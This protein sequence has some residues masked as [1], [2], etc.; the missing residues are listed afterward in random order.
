MDLL[1][2]PLQRLL[3]VEPGANLLESL[4]NAQIP[5][6]YSC[7][8]GRC[9]TCRCRVVNGEVLESGQVPQNPFDGRDSYVLACQTYITEPCTIEIPE[10]DEVVVHPARILKTTVQ[11]IEALTHDIRRLVLKPARPIA[12]SPGQYAQLQFTP[13]LVRPYSM[14]GVAGDGMLEFHVRIV[15]GGR[16]S[17]YIAN[18]LRPGDAVRV[19]GPLGTAYLRQKHVGPMLCVA[20]GTG[21]APILSI[22]RSA[23]FGGMRNPVHL[24]FGVR[25]AEDVYGLDWLAD[26]AGRH[27]G[28]KLNVVVTSGS[29]IRGQ[30]RGLVTEAIEEDFDSLEGWRA[31]LC[32]SP[33]MVEAA[34]VLARQMG[35]DPTRIY[36]DAFY[37]Q[38]N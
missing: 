8:A 18:E 20:G 31:Y 2:Q 13:D 21:L 7:M 14:A 10:P 29:E 27:P 16:V 34:T 11:S 4:R 3:D 23:I 32:G 33:P 19:S 38:P 5:M 25:S 36:A 6:S 17:G 26:L 28:L 22:L 35:I 30:R 12:F 9:G 1:I 37:T 24:Y 15:P